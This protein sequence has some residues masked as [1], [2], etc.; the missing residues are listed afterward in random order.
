MRRRPAKLLL[1]LATVVLAACGDNTPAVVEQ[2]RS[3]KT[4]TVAELASGQVRR[5]S[6]VVE[7][8]DTSSL[9]FQVA[10]NVQELL[11]DRGDRVAAGQVLAI[12]D[13]RAYTLTVDA[14]ESELGRAGAVFEE[15]QLA[16]ARQ[17][18]L[19]DKQ[20]VSKAALDQAVAAFETARNDVAYSNSRLNLARR[21]LD[22]AVLTAPFDGVIA[23]RF[24]DAFAEVARGQGI[25]EIFAE[26]AMQVALNIPETVIEEINIGLPASVRLATQPGA[27]QAFVTEL[28]S[29][30]V[31]AN[32]FPVKTTLIDPPASVRPG[33]TAE[34]T[35]LLTRA[36]EAPGYLVPLA[37]IAPGDGPARGY[38][39]VY[40]PETSTVRKAPIRAGPGRDSRV[41]VFEGVKAGDIIAV[42]GVS[43]LSDGQKVALLQP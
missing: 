38:V 3:I 6:G 2:V 16:L 24:V 26:D 27:H 30:A 1:A 34:V 8:T 13:A 9:G 42:A 11:V 10:G 5:F 31:E 22:L 25:F 33:M 21:D 39:F 29:V 7:A 17:Q 15:K 23:D 14:A 19:F 41:A 36:D 4:I 43:F 18:E 35:F 40:D 20:W 32:A 12:L 37:A 28:G